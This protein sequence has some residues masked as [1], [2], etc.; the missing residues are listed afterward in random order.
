MGM[1]NTAHSGDR[2]QTLRTARDA[3]ARQIDRLESNQSANEAPGRDIAVLTKELSR[4]MEE[5][6]ELSPAD[7]GDSVDDL[8]KKR[9]RRLALRRSNPSA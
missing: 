8:T 3:I 6:A 7:H 9:E 1:E 2:L 5:L 4:L